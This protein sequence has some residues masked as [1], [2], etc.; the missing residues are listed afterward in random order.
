MRALYSTILFLFALVFRGQSLEKAQYYLDHSDYR[1]AVPLYEKIAKEARQ[2][3]NLDLEVTAQNGLADCYLDLGATYKAMALLKKNSTELNKPITKNYLLLAKTH[4]LLAI[5]YDKLNLIEDYLK[6]CNLFYSYYQK[7]APDKEIYKAL[8][9]AYVG[10]YYNMRFIIDKAF[11]YTSTALKIYHKH[12][13]EKEVDPY[14]FYN[15]H[16]FTERNHTPSFDIKL[17]YIDSLTYFINKRYP[18]DNLKKA[19]ILISLAA[20]NLDIVE[21]INIK[22]SI[23]VNINANIAIKYYEHAISI[24]DKYSGYNNPI[25]A[26]DYSLMGLMYFYKKDYYSALKYYEEGI[27]RLT[28]NFD[29][30]NRIFNNNY[31][32]F[33]G[34]LSWKTWCLNELYDKQE[35]I[36]LL[37]DI[38]H[39]LE[40]TE[41]IWIRY[42][43]QQIKSNKD[44]NINFYADCPYLLMV[45]NYKKLYQKTNNNIYLA[46]IVEYDQKSRYSSLLENFIKNNL[47]DSK[48]MFHLNEKIDNIFLHTNGKINYKDSNSV[49]E[50]VNSFSKSINETEN[51]ILELF[52]KNIPKI[53]E[54][55][56]SI[57]ADDALI[58]Y[59]NTG[60][61][62]FKVAYS[63]IITKNKIKII[64]LNKSI[65]DSYF[66]DFK[67]DNLLI[68][69]G[70]ND[71]NSFEIQSYYF[72]KNFFEPIKNELSN[73]I[74]NL[75]IIPNAVIENFPF[76]LIISKPSNNI[77]SFNKLPY[78]IKKYNF[79]YSLSTTLS[80]I[81]QKKDSKNN[82]LSIFSPSIV[83]KNYTN[84]KFTEEKSK[85]ISK[86]YDANHYNGKRATINSFSNSITKDKIV[87]LFSHGKS[88]LDELDVQKGIYLS[89]GFLSL[90][91]V[92]KLN[93]NCDFL[94]LVAC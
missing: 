32:V 11:T 36:Q 66:T 18:Y 68:S 35:D 10:R 56:K 69:L 76:D 59:N 40:I 80:K 77:T 47:D 9:Y 55:Q 39:D 48:D 25:S 67:L 44:Y 53:K 26:F 33:L 49:I 61:H 60:N 12:P 51:K 91:D 37:Y 57:K 24:N 19:R 14:I 21:R 74:K 82:K 92:Y 64:N 90:N 38:Q 65:F 16:L 58:F 2:V 7:A 46:K 78:L 63:I 94:L 13:D 70:K 50:N 54:L 73:N 4:Q 84:L 22:D 5:A 8:Y 34:L 52:N 75:T 23:Q 3:N 17:K 83:S 43:N 27:K 89:D 93:S 29:K 86:L 20:P 71:I 45:N 88:N 30:Q 1:H 41:K 42:S 81:N 87:F 15:A 85:E 62:S 72:Y 28:V 6:E 79:N 31:I